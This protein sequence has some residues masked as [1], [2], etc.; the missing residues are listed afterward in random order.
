L[1]VFVIDASITVNWA[2]DDEESAA[3]QTAFD[4]L[5]DGTGHVPSLWWFET[6]NSL[7]L[8]ERRGRLTQ[9]ACSAF[10][11]MIGRLK[12]VMDSAPREA[13]LLGLVRQHRLTVYDAAYLELA[14]R[15]QVPLATLDRALARAAQSEGIALIGA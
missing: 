13:S 5:R 15:L 3:A 14:I 9:A 12:I 11:A 1:T 8:A 10:L 7:L 2:M 4:L 6:R